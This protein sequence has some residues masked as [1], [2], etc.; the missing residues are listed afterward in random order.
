MHMHISIHTS[1]THSAGLGLT[2]TPH[3]SDVGR[4]VQHGRM[5]VHGSAAYVRTYETRPDRGCVN[6][7]S[8]R[9]RADA[10]KTFASYTGIRA[11]LG[12]NS[13]QHSYCA[14]THMHTHTHTHTHSHSH[15]RALSLS[16]SLSRA[17]SLSLSLAWHVRQAA[18]THQRVHVFLYSQCLGFGTG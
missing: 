15:A 14:H 12:R 1:R 11:G 6:T 8:R 2:K 4:L 5:C 9:P 17:L 3:A 18:R 7:C 16:L 10:S 13:Q